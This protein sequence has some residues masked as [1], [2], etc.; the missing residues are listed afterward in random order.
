MVLTGCLVGRP[1]AGGRPGPLNAD[2]GYHGVSVQGSL[3][4]GG[5]DGGAHHG[6]PTSVT[7]TTPLGGFILELTTEDA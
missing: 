4:R 5:A 1:A 3:G 2:N 7:I 6:R